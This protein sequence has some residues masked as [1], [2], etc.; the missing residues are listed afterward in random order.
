MNFDQFLRRACYYKLKEFH[1]FKALYLTESGVCDES[2]PDVRVCNVKYE[3]Y[4][5]I[6]GVRYNNIQEALITIEYKIMSEAFINNF[7]LNINGNT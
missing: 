1:V 5:M 2:R 3:S 7:E 4:W 6:D